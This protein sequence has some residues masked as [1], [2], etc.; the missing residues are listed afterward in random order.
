MSLN[1]ANS[2][3]ER[4]G[5][6][7]DVY[8]LLE[9]LPWGICITD[10]DDRICWANPSFCEQLGIKRQDAAS[11]RLNA[12]PL[13]HSEDLGHGIYQVRN[14]HERRLRVSSVVIE[15]DHKLTLFTD[16][17]DLVPD[18][19]GY[20]DLLLEVARMDSDTGLLTP[21][22]IYRELF[23]QVSRSRRYGNALAI[24]RIEIAGLQTERINSKDREHALRDFGVK[25]ADNVRNIDFAGRL[26]DHE[27][28]IVL[29]ETDI[30][31]VEILIEKLR[32]MLAMP[33]VATTEGDTVQCTTRY[34]L[35]EWSKSDDVSAL[36]DKARPRAQTP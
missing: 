11:T 23:T 27:F 3:G 30:E 17:S 8:R 35:A 14:H 26:S 22:S 12:L 13:V 19:G 7:N 32:P 33:P 18:T 36:L 21:A 6:S 25:L 24:V 15:N 2:P 29:P 10:A 9:K 20:A 16:V 31:G 5:L 4:P 1:D 34:G 28:L